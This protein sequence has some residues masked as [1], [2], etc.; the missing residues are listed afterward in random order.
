MRRGHLSNSRTGRPGETG[1][2]GRRFGVEIC[3]AREEEGE[4]REKK[5][6]SK[7]ER[8]ES[9]GDGPSVTPPE[10]TRI[11]ILSSHLLFC[12]SPPSIPI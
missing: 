9:E 3:W 8:G 10:M 11:N 4:D 2:E 1:I 12:S 5:E 7:E 6:E